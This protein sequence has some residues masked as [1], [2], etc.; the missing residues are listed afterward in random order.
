MANKKIYKNRLSLPIFDN[1]GMG[2]GNGIAYVPNIIR[3]GSAIPI[4]NNMFFMKGKSHS[5]GGI[6]IGKDLEVE[7]NE[8]VQNGKFGTRVF[9]SVPFLRGVS[10][11]Q[12]V[13]QGENPDAVF[14][15]QEN[16]KRINKINDD[17]SRKARKGK[18][19][20]N[21]NVAQSDNTRV[22][23]I[24]N[25]PPKSKEIRQGDYL[26]TP[27]QLVPDDE[28]GFVWHRHELRHYGE[29]KG[30]D[31]RIMSENSRRRS[32]CSMDRG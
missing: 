3:G 22:A 21:P 6:D 19:V 1:K 4:G 12:R 26:Y 28:K 27:K 13:L 18:Y 30:G 9:S 8:V 25:N 16:W 32:F 10:P 14:A 7:R 5:Q 23:P 31:I 2:N 24:L 11:A 15:A 20:T 29:Y 17:G